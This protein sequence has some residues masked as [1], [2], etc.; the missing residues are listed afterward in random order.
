MSD[1]QQA[2]DALNQ[3]FIYKY[4]SLAGYI[5]KA[6]PYVR[7]GQEAALA[8]VE[9][10]AD[11]DRIEADRLALSMES[12]E[13]IP[14]AGAAPMEVAAVNYLAIDFL[15]GVLRKDLERQSAF[16]EVTLQR[17]D[18]QSRVRD[19]FDRLAAATRH[20]LEQVCEWLANGPEA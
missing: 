13:G 8:L 17:F 16:Y 14:Q 7:A 9:A 4:H 19:D 1:R 3:A 11:E 20:H 12:L 18:D 5:V 10:M 6:A 15:L 2:I